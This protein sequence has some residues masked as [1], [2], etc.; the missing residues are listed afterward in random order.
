MYG[1]QSV[2]QCEISETQALVRVSGQ[3]W[4]ERRASACVFNLN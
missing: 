2:K 4:L 1:F 3:K